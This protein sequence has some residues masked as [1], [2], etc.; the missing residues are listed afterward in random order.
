MIFRLSGKEDV[1]NWMDLA[2][3]EDTE[4]CGISGRGSYF[5]VGGGLKFEI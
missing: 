4:Q 2:A 3:Q 5:E 1:K